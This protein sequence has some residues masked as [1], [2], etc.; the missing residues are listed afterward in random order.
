MTT[1]YGIK[2]C[3]TIKKARKWLSDHDVDYEFHDYRKDGI[4]ADWLQQQ[5]KA[6]GWEKLLNRR[7]MM[8]RKLPDEV[9]NNLDESTAIK[10]MLETPAIIKRPL[11]IK[12]KTK[13]LGFD[14]KEYAEKLD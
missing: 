1:M 2:N 4:D 6:F 8:W 5:V 14:E 3:D 12:G 10:I 7:G 11:L 13:L 9:K